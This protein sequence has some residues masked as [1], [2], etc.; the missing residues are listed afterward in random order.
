MPTNQMQSDVPEVHIIYK[1]F[2]GH[3][4]PTD[5]A[6]SPQHP[7]DT[8]LIMSPIELMMQG[9]SGHGGHGPTGTRGLHST[10]LLGQHSCSRSKD[11][12]Y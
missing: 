1:G 4:L 9:S 10:Y 5:A 6:F 12:S 2:K 7:L 8:R 3:P 11:P